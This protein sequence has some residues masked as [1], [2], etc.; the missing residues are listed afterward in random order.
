VKMVRGRETE[1][2]CN[3]SERERLQLH[4]DDE[5]DVLAGA[6][7][8]CYGNPSRCAASELKR[9]NKCRSV[10]R[11]APFERGTEEAIKK[12]Y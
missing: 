5:I 2:G 3:E 8:S 7:R 6:G 4:A 11:V 1:I 12:F 10:R 9:E